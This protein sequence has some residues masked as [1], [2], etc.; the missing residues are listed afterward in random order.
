VTKV[1]LPEHKKF[2]FTIVDDTD[3]AFL[4]NIQPL[5]DFLTER[6]VFIT[7][8]VW[9]YP[10]RDCASA[11]DSLANPKYLAYI[12]ELKRRGFEIALHNVGS[13]DYKRDEIVR[14]LEEY[15]RLIGEYPKIHINHSYNPDNIYS[16][17]RRF[18]FP[19]DVVIKLLYSQYGR[20]HGDD[21]GSPYFW[22]DI[23]KRIIKFNRNYEFDE[24]NTLK[25]NPEMPYREARYQKYSN[26]WFSATFAP[27]QWC[28]NHIVT[29]RA[30]DRLE[31]EG[32]ICILYTHLGYYRKTGQIDPG[33]M[34]R[35]DYISSKGTGLYIP[36]SQV[37]EYLLEVR[38]GATSLNPVRRLQLEFHHLLTRFKYRYIKRI[39]DYTFKQ[40]Y[41]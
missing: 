8:T 26:Y 34:E 29:K 36:V 28:F 25:I 2:V 17:V 33:F 30:V 16:G 35:I 40:T 14:G 7:K 21:E 27:N 12:L 9:V 20:F 22:G 37:L 10:P 5:Y 31:E 38:G 1:S 3:D 18:G 23:H 11:G 19:F 15:R 32:G 4:E 13:G 24:L 41:A 39:D 6:R